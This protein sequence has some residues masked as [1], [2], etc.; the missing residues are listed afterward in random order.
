MLSGKDSTSSA[1]TWFFWLVAGHPRVEQSIY[2]ELLSA[3]RTDASPGNGPGNLDYDELKKLHYLHAAISETLRLFPPVP[4]NS[5]LVLSDDTLSDGT[6]VYKGWFADYSAYAM[7]RMER[8]WGPDCK[9]FRPERWLDDK[10]VFQQ[11]DPFKFPVFH[12]GPRMCL[13]K[14][15]AYVQM[16]SIA[17]A[18]MY[19]FK[20]IAIDGGGIPERIVN[21]PYTLSLLLKM[22]G[23]FHVRLQRRQLPERPQSGQA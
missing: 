2:D 22:K 11:C 23:G 15:M 16:K 10:G 21:P 6:C 9:E 17:A 20:V 12:C 14:E 19:E 13:G 7:G 18:V 1:L 4:I 3:T 5:R 8:L